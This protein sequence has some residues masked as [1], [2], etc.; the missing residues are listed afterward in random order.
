MKLSNKTKKDIEREITKY[1]KS[2]DIKDKEGIKIGSRLAN[3]PHV[4]L[5][6]YKQPFFLSLLTDN[7]RFYAKM[8]FKN[9]LPYKAWRD[10]V[11]KT[12]GFLREKVEDFQE[13]VNPR[14]ERK[15]SR[16]RTGDPKI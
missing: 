16:G 13:L 3:T 11:G 1:I 15:T 2:L 9:K 7:E 12:P 5:E 6:F 4:L 10:Y 8:F 14:Y